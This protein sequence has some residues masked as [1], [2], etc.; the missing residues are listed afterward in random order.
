[1]ARMGK[2]V[3]LCDLDFR[4]PSVA[5]ELHIQDESGLCSILTDC[6]VSPSHVMQLVRKSSISE[7]FDVLVAG[8]MPSVH[9]ANLLAHENLKKT[10]NHLRKQYD[11]ILLDTSAVGQYGDIL[12]DGL[13]DMTCYVCRLGKTPKTAIYHLNELAESQ[14]LASP[15]IILNQK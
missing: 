5:R 12:I 4:H 1:M 15:V 11:L 14:R 6:E 7:D 3:L 9:P 10:L 2:H 8:R 13:A